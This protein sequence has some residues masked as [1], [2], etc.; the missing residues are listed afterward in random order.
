MMYSQQE[1]DM[2]RRQTMQIEAEKR[3]LLRWALIAVTL[4]LAGALMLTGWM[5]TRYSAADSE[6]QDALARAR[7]VEGQFQQVSRE[8][9]EKKSI[10]EKSASSLSKQNEVIQTT[11]PKILN[12]TAR[13]QELGEF[14]HAVF[15]QPGHVIE[16]PG[17][18]PDAVLR[19]YRIRIDDRPLK[20]TMVAGLLNGKWHLYSVLVKNQEDR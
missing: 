12:R 17:I 19:S 8:L 9:A 11:I 2:V 6:V 10:L 5:Y 16:L 1:Y 3:A 18:P 20:Y 13:D 15:Q 7:T 4:F 14:A